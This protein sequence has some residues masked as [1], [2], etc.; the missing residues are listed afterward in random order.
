MITWKCTPFASLSVDDLYAAM[1]LRQEVFVVEQKCAY[2]D[3][4]GRDPEALH[5]LGRSHAAPYGLVAYA[6]L[7][8]SHMGHASVIG[9][10]ITHASVRRGGMGKAL[11]REA[12]D[13]LEKLAPHH[14]IELGA[15]MYLTRFYEGFG[16]RVASEPYDEDGIPHVKMHRDVQ[17]T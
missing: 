11:M 13:R 7:F 12:I 15:Q 3:A 16:F 5:L 1:R 17:R 4:D 6:R 2:L 10:V 14:A 9:R 8:V